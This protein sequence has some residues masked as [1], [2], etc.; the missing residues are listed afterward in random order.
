MQVIAITVTEYTVFQTG[1]GEEGVEV[2][3]ISEDTTS[4]AIGAALSEERAAQLVADFCRARPPTNDGAEEGSEE[5]RPVAH[6]SLSCVE[7]G[8][9][10]SPSG[11]LWWAHVSE[12]PDPASVL[13]QIRSKREPRKEAPPPDPS[14]L[15][16]GDLDG[17]RVR[18][19]R[20]DE[21]S[22]LAERLVRSGTSWAPTDDREAMHA[23][24]AALVARE[25][26]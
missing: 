15:W 5:V 9:P 24:E 8:A 12:D 14:V 20:M 25:A 21:Q 7:L 1:E 4:Y 16:E 13:A 6:V 2:D 17:Q 11:P 23:F 10:L 19:R 18:V 3:V 22:L 26:R